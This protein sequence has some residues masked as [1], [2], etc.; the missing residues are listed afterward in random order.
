LLKSSLE[1]QKDLSNNAL[2]LPGRFLFPWFP[3]V[4]F[5]PAASAWQLF[6]SALH[7]LGRSGFE[8]THPEGWILQTTSPTHCL[9]FQC[10]A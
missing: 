7:V 9:G 4:L 3:T 8:T 10:A 2:E 1:E 6:G 5:S